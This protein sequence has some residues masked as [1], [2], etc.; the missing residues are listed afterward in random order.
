MTTPRYVQHMSGQGEKWEVYTE[1]PHVWS[2]V[3]PLDATKWL[4]FPKSE[5]VLCDPPQRWVDVTAECEVGVIYTGLS[6]GTEQ[7]SGPIKE[8]YRL[9]KVQVNM[10]AQLNVPSEWAFIVEKMETP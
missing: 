10:R 6:I 2:I 5:Y 4:Q 1:F 3:S 8:G 7:I 9:R